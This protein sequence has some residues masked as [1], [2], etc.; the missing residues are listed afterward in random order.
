MQRSEDINATIIRIL[1]SMD[2]S[3]AI[4]S[5]SIGYFESP[6]AFLEAARMAPQLVAGTRAG[7]KA[8]PVS[9]AIK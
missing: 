1:K 9:A 3:N 6:N 5:R 2:R 4:L 7:P 8:S